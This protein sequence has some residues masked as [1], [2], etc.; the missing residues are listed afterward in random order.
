MKRIFVIMQTIIIICVSND[1]VRHVRPGRRYYEGYIYTIDGQPI[2]DLKVYPLSCRYFRCTESD[3]AGWMTN[4]YGYFKFG[5]ARYWVTRYLIIES[6]GRIIDSI[7]RGM[8]P[9]YRKPSEY[10]TFDDRTADTFFVDME[11]KGRSF[12][13]SQ[14]EKRLERRYYEGYIYTIEG[15]PIRNLNVYSS[16]CQRFECTKAESEGG[17]TNERGYFKFERSYYFETRYLLIG[18]EERNIDSIDRGP[19]HKTLPSTFDDKT[20]DTFFVDMEG[21]GRSFIVRQGEQR[22]QIPVE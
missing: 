1:C 4:E 15:Q 14:G 12:K 9:H 5:Q 11:G 19:I 3:S 2:R 18:S 6:E 10:T 17:I 7:D 21:K 16:R 13:V 22:K 8:L 20:A